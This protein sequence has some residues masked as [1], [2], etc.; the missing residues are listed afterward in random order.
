MQPHHT[1]LHQA[2]P[3]APPALLSTE[4]PAPFPIPIPIPIPANP[5]LTELLSLSPPPPNLDAVLPNPGG[6]LATLPFFS[7]PPPTSPGR[8]VR[9]DDARLRLS[10]FPDEGDD[11]SS[12]SPFTTLPP[13][14]FDRVAVLA[15]L[16]CRLPTGL[17]LDVDEWRASAFD[18]ASDLDFDWE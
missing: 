18:P 14:F 2:Q 13:P 1:T 10:S 4:L 9:C 7:P 11:S 17:L 15:E 3:L 8:T 12:T 6:T 16:P 5:K